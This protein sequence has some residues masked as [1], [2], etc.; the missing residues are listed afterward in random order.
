MQLLKASRKP[1]AEVSQTSACREVIIED[2]PP[3]LLLL[4]RNSIWTM[5]YSLVVSGMRTKCKVE[6][7][8]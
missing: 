6:N 8:P 1:R 4:L 7:I 2:T 3:L 5:P